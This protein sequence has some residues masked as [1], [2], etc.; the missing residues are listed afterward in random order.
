MRTLIDL[1]AVVPER[2]LGQALSEAEYLKLVTAEE[3]I[4][5]L[6]AVKRPGARNLRSLLPDTGPTR[7]ELERRFLALCRHAGLPEPFINEPMAVGD[8]IIRPDFHWR[9]A[10]L[11]V[12]VDGFEGHGTRSAFERDRDRDARLVAARYRVVRFTWRQVRSEPK[13]V[14]EVLQRLLLP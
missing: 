11:V 6:A 8:R 3:V 9:E 10:R 12:E 5:E 2:V 4:A 7:R 1:S 13:A 14:L